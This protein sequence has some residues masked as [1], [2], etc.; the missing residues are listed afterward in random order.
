MAFRNSI[1]SIVPEQSASQFRK[2]SRK[3]VPS[4]PPCS[5]DFLSRTLLMR[6]TKSVT[7]LSGFAL[8]AWRAACFWANF[9]CVHRLGSNGLIIDK[10]TTHGLVRWRRVAS[11]A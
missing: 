4:V 7:F 2:H 6:R 11:M 9:T 3:Y 10:E 8:F 5:L 1:A